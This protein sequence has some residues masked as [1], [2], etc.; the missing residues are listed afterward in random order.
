[1]LYFLPPPN[2]GIRRNNASGCSDCYDHVRSADLHLAQ[3]L[4][5]K[6]AAVDLAGNRDCGCAR[7]HQRPRQ[8]REAHQQEV[9]CMLMRLNIEPPY[10]IGGSL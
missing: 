8:P 3:Q 4:V 2:Y 9:K 6:L 10:H 5:R 1:M 7:L